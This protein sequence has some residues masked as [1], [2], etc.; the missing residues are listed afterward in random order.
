VTVLV[1]RGD[2]RGSNEHRYEWWEPADSPAGRWLVDLGRSEEAQ[3]I[4][5]WDYMAEEQEQR[6]EG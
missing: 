5:G 4:A 1:P 6:Q 2:D 3:L